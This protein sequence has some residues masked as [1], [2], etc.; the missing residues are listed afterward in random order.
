[1]TTTLNF[2][3]LTWIHLPEPDKNEIKKLIK[4]YDFHELIEED[5]FELSTQEKIDVYEKN[6]FIVV[7]FP[8]YD[9]DIKKYVL[10][11]FSI[12]MGKNVIVTM[13]RFKTNHV[14]RII[15]EYK[16]ELRERDLD[17]DFKISP[18]YILYKI[19]DT[20]YDKT[21]GILNKSSKDVI[22]FEEELFQSK[23]LA[24]T[25]LENLM[26]KKRNIA[27]LK[28]IFLPHKEILDELQKIVPKFYKWDLDVYFEDL[29]Y[30]LDKILNNIEISFENV[31]SLADTYNS[32][33]NIKT[34][35]VINILTIFTAITWVLT[36]ISWIYGMNISLPGQT[37]W[38]F[39]LII[40]GIMFVVSV[41]LIWI[42]KKQKWI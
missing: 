31:D 35:S 19:M 11:E 1:M 7:N 3:N 2:G 17:E 38:Y 8:K 9:T 40:I 21:V 5:L 37:R 28:H 33:M 4:R 18:Y 26:I 41:C 12:V 23:K 27:F 30:K 22:A 14:E 24:K 6:I 34:N 29:A 39:F 32:L 15:N 20:M 25:L 13:T 10:N 16:K 36:L 42:F